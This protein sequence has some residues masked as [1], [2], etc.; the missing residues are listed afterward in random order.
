MNPEERMMNVKAM[1]GAKLAELRK[2]YRNKDEPL[3]KNAF[4]LKEEFKSEY[5]FYQHWTCS[6]TNR[7]IEQVQYKFREFFV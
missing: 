4:S 1:Y 3:V 6:I 2:K 5:P 7:V